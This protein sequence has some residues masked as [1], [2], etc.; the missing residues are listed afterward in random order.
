MQVQFVQPIQSNF[1]ENKEKVGNFL[2]NHP[3]VISK[4]AQVGQRVSPRDPTQESPSSQKQSVVEVKRENIKEQTETP[5]M[6][7]GFNLGELISS[8]LS[9]IKSALSLFSC[10]NKTNTKPERQEILVANLKKPSANPETLHEVA[11]RLGEHFEKT[12]QLEEKEQILASQGIFRLSGSQSNINK[13]YEELMRDPKR[14]PLPLDKDELA[15]LFKKVY[16]NLNLF[17]ASN[18]LNSKF[19]ETALKLE[20]EADS[21]KIIEALQALINELSPGRREDLGTFLKILFL[22]SQKENKN[23][24]TIANLAVAAGPNLNTNTTNIQAIQATISI[25]TRL[26]ENYE[27]LNFSTSI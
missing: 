9:G 20:N 11:Q 25:A 18:G 17:G 21:N 1:L 14:A 27:K 19:E 4:A 13:A 24:M 26:I 16:H 10:F 15:C 6:R 22:T 2:E 7:K 12:E 3:E 8:I 5:Q 23:K